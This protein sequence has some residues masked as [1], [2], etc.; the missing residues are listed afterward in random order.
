[1]ALP[2]GRDSQPQL[3]DPFAQL[4]FPQRCL[5]L[6]GLKCVQVCLFSYK[7]T[8]LCLKL[9]IQFGDTFI[10]RAHLPL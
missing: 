1:M 4:F 8:S 3:I 2:P 5:S 7:L 9:A 6:R 10:G